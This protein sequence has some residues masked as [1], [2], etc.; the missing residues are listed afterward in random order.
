MYEVKWIA[1]PSNTQVVR[2]E[3]RRHVSPTLKLSFR[4]ENIHN[5]KYKFNC[6]L[7]ELPSQALVAGAIETSNL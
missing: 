7:H 4:E 5:L 2:A 1:Q 3:N 6:A